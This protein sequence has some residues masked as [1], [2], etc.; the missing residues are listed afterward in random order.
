VKG[1]WLFDSFVLVFNFYAC[2]AYLFQNQ[3]TKNPEALLWR[4]GA[5]SLFEQDL[6]SVRT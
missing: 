4:A 2:W 3:K 5:A 6:S 1:F